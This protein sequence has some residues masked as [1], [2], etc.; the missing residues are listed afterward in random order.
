MSVVLVGWTPN[1]Y[2]AAALARGIEEARLR[3][4][5]L[6]VVNATR[7]DALVDDRYATKDQVA[8]LSEELEGSGLQAEVRQEMAPDVAEAL[9]DAARDSGAELVVL[10]I[11]HRTPVG[12]LLMGSV[13]QRVIL[14]AECAVLAVKP[15]H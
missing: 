2:G 15:P 3:G 4:L 6:L 9:L 12:K 5:G 8:A 14:E 13:A 1:E 10:G 7:G 11:R